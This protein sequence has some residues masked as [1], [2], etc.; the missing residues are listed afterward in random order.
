MQ[1]PGREWWKRVSEEI[2]NSQCWPRFASRWF[3]SSL[4]TARSHSHLQN[5]L[6]CS[7]F[8]PKSVKGTAHHIRGLVTLMA[9]CILSK[10]SMSINKEQLGWPVYELAYA[11][12]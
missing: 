8:K 9:K 6:R 3:S 10:V 1:R 12:H 11:K 7:T 5:K 2:N 4:G